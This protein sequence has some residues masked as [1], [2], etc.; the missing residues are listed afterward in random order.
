M[1]TNAYIVFMLEIIL[2]IMLLPL[3]HVAYVL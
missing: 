3:M 2:M 1:M